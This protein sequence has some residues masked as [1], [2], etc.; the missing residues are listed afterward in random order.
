MLQTNLSGILGKRRIKQ[1]ELVKRTG[2]SPTT[3]GS[4]YHD[5][6]KHVSRESIEK[7]CAALEI[8]ISELFELVEEN[9]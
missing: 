7:I 6:W 9:E 1:T 2:L 8:D 5:N 4:I 3:I